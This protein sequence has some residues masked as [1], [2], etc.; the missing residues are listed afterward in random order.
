M[1]RIRSAPKLDSIL[2]DI[3]G[4]IV[5]GEYSPGCRLPVRSELEGTYDV[6]WATLQKA[7]D[8]LREDGFIETRG[9]HGTFV[10]GHP[11]H[12]CEYALVFPYRPGEAD[13]W[14]RYYATLRQQAME[15]PQ[16][17]GRRISTYYTGH[18]DT[19]SRDCR[20]LLHDVNRHRLAGIILSGMAGQTGMQ[21]LLPD[22]LPKVAISSMPILG[23][24]AV[25]PDMFTFWDRSL[26]YVR[27]RGLR[28]I[29][30]FSFLQVPGNWERVQQ[31][32]QRHGMETRPYWNLS[33]E[34][35][36]SPASAA[37]LLSRLPK[38]D[39]PEAMIISDDNLVESTMTGLV[40]GGIKTPEELE[41]VIHCNFPNPPPRILPAA[42]IGFDCRVVL[43]T[44]CDILEKQRQGEAV[45]ARTAL[46]AV[47]EKELSGSAREEAP[48][49]SQEPMQSQ[50]RWMAT[51]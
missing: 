46:G 17:E 47:T 23:A 33:F 43:R 24:P 39:R 26:E 12:L 13:S 2:E 48:V 25:D 6:S 11:P 35:S 29:A 8:L 22:W 40:A 31:S 30:T 18:G 1:G 34:G 37:H 27:S 45:P 5:T 14:S 41:L 51:V 42:R 38:E 49:E 19:S 50:G 32:M 44:C 7:F 20:E 4:R 36:Q 9:R 21:K 3:R 16:N 15:S 28:R 10:A